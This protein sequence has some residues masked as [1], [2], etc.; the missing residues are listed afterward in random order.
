MRVEG[1][2]LIL[3]RKK[4]AEGSAQITLLCK[5]NGIKKGYCKISSR[6]SSSSEVGSLVQYHGNMKDNSK[7]LSISKF[8]LIK[9]YTLNFL[10][11][12]KEL[13]KVLYVTGLVEHIFKENQGDKE[14]YN[15]IIKFCESLPSPLSTLIKF[16]LNILSMSGYGLDLK[17][18]N[19]TNN[20]T[21]LA[22][23]SPKTGGALSFEYGNK[24]AD[25]LFKLPKWLIENITPSVEDIEYTAKIT[26]FFL[27]RYFFIEKNQLLMDFR[28]NSFKG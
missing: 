20:T 7:F 1:K 28:R 16:E 4:V 13:Y 8:E 15:M 22:Y 12:T 24:F 25:K 2:A 14:I 18:C 6:N 10:D 17:R 21:N 27:N 11:N 3:S 26:Q 9:S 19:A 5:E 23:I